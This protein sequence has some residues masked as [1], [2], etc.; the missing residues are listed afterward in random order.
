MGE[1]LSI[2]AGE[3][4]ARVLVGHDENRSGRI[5][6]VCDRYL[7]IVA[8]HGPTLRLA[9]WC[10]A[11]D[12]LNGAWMSDEASIRFMWAE[13]ADCEGLGDKWG[14]DQP[15]LTERIRELPLAAKVAMMEVVERF[16][17]R[18]D[19]STADA[20]ALAGAKIQPEP[21]PEP[22]PAPPA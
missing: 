11:C 10:A 1:K 22:E 18:T 4:M 20:L 9:E 8:E 21:E 5:N 15:A 12:A 2:Y 6:T 7:S 17:G 13:I 19:L 14:I 3:P 16:W